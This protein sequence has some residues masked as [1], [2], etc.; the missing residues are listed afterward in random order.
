MR[1]FQMLSFPS[2]GGIPSRS[3]EKERR[4]LLE[5]YLLFANPVELHIV[6]LYIKNSAVRTFVPN[7]GEI[8]MGME[9]EFGHN[10]A[11][12]LNDRLMMMMLD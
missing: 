8:R 11:N 4:A 6:K 5:L 12:R 10:G 2:V 7:I 9:L 1:I 3:L